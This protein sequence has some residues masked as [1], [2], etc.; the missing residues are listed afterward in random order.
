MSAIASREGFGY[1]DAVGCTLFFAGAAVIAIHP[2]ELEEL[3]EGE[4]VVGFT[5]EQEFWSELWP[6]PCNY[7]YEQ[8]FRILPRWAFSPGGGERGPG[9]RRRWDVPAGHSYRAVWQC[10]LRQLGWERLAELGDR[11]LAGR[12]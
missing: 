10:Q 12:R 7:Y 11:A 5:L 3:R 9:L 4:T 8:A 6:Q 1:S 2:P